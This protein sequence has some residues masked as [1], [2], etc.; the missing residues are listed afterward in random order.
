MNEPDRQQQIIYLTLKLRNTNQSITDQQAIVE[1]A[2]RILAVLQ[3]NRE[4]YQT[5]LR[6]LGVLPLDDNQIG[7]D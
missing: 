7:V 6:E 2:Q 1:K 3:D 4:V 5:R